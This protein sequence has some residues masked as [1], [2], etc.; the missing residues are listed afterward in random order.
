MYIQF[1]ESTNADQGGIKITDDGVAVFGAGD[2]D[3]FK[4]INED[5][6]EQIFVVNDSGAGNP[7]GKGQVGI[8]KAFTPG[9]QTAMN[10][11]LDVNGN[12]IITGSL[13]VTGSYASPAGNTINSN[14]LIQASLLYL[15]NNF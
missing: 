11:A 9:N 10:A 2:E 3:L 1:G 12:A 4:V 15:S 5:T 13:T 14:A 7:F 6:N 8:N